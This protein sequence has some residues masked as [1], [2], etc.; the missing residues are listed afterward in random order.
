MGEYV[1]NHFIVFI[2]LVIIVLYCASI[3]GTIDT[4]DLAY[5]IALSFSIIFYILIIVSYFYLSRNCQRNY[6]QVISMFILPAI[7]AGSIVG[8]VKTEDESIVYTLSNLVM[9]LSGIFIFSIA[10]TNGLGLCSVIIQQTQDTAATIVSPPTQSS[11]LYTDTP[12]AYS[13]LPQERLSPNINLPPLTSHSS[14]P[15]S[16]ILIEK[17]NLLDLYMNNKT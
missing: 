7:L 17:P 11:I 14:I 10:T 8:L 1:S 13:L 6:I 3:Y 9:W 15:S 16:K 2:L 12:P 5:K 4:S